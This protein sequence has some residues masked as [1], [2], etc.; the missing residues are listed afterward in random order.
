[1]RRRF[2]A[3]QPK[4]QCSPPPNAVD[5]STSLFGVLP[6]TVTVAVPDEYL[7]HRLSRARV[8]A[9][10]ACSYKAH[11]PALSF[12]L[13][14]NDMH[15]LCAQLISLSALCDHDFRRDAQLYFI[16]EGTQPIYGSAH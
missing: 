10:L 9:G 11:C 4:V 6:F 14:H 5:D 16:A 8:L 7:E 13:F 1:M 12:F 3:G 15:C 2:V